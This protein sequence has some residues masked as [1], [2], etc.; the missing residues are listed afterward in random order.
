MSN[1]I[2]A[3]SQPTASSRLKRALMLAIVCAAGLAFVPACSPSDTSDSGANLTADLAMVRKRSFEITTTASGQLEAKSEVEIRS[4]VESRTTIV[5]LAK[6][7]TLV[8]AGDLLVQL[9]SDQIEKS[10]VD[11]NARVQASKS[12]LVTA[13]NNLAMQEIENTSRLRRAELKL[14]LARSAMAQWR[15]GDVAIRRMTL[16]LTVAKAVR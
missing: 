15:Q 5:E 6:E 4:K 9:A 13:E 10:I 3:M 8:K 2:N 1:M 16:E 11:E 7:G 14:D 12:D